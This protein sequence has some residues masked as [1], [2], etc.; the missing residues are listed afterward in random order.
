MAAA[1]GAWLE[2]VARPPSSPRVSAGLEAI[3]GGDWGI[4][5]SIPLSGGHLSDKALEFTQ[6]RH[7]VRTT[8]VSEGRVSV[9]LS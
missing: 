9:S 5:C 8:R 4:L 1:G 2:M 3:A 7:M 6:I